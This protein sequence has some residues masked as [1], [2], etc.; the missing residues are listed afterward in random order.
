MLSEG[1]I[2]GDRDLVLVSP[3]N[4][5]IL[6]IKEVRTLTG[7]GLKEAKDLIDSA[8]TLVMRQISSERADAAK[9]LLE[10]LGATVTVSSDPGQ[11]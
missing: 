9:E 4:R 3:G 1:G 7:L 11:A 2:D 8:P 10:R 5:K 6:V